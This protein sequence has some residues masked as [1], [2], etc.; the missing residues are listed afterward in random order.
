MY[1]CVIIHLFLLIF[2]LTLRLSF[3]DNTFIIQHAHTPLF[4]TTQTDTDR[5]RQHTYKEMKML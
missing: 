5:E 4:A 2:W 3:S 1:V